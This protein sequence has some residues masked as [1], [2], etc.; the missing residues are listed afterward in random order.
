MSWYTTLPGEPRI[1]AVLA[2]P[3]APSCAISAAV[4]AVAVAASVLA[5]AMIMSH[6]RPR[7]G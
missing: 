1:P 3:M 4:V 6:T 7:A 2:T 5:R